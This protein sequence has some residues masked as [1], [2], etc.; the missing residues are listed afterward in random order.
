MLVDEDER[1]YYKTKEILLWR[2]YDKF[3]R[4]LRGVQDS[5]SSAKA[6]HDPRSMSASSSRDF[7]AMS[8]A[9]KTLAAPLLPQS[10]GKGSANGVT[11]DV[12]PTNETEDPSRQVSKVEVF[13]E[14]SSEMSSE[15]LKDVKSS[16]PLND[17]CNEVPKTDS[18]TQNGGDN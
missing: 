7:S 16:G 12:Y 6:P 15:Y 8:N 10:A 1:R 3:Y 17:N 18:V 4:K 5:P 2:K 13:D 9:T 11:A 14:K